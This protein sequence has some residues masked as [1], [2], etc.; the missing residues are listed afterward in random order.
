MNRCSKCGSQMVPG[1]QFCM[2]CGA[3]FS[4]S[5][6]TRRSRFRWLPILGVLLI[7]AGAAWSLTA[8]GV[9]SL[10]SKH[11]ELNA[12][13][14]S[15]AVGDPS[16]SVSGV[17]NESSVLAEPSQP[18]DPALELSNEPQPPSLIVPESGMP[19]DIRRWLEHLKRVDEKRESLNIELTGELMGLVATLRP[20]TFSEED[21][22]EASEDDSRRR[23]TAGE[24]I[25][26]VDAIFSDLITEFQSFPPPPQCRTIAVQYNSALFGTREISIELMEALSNLDLQAAQ[27]L[28]GKSYSKVDS[29]VATANRLVDGL[30]S[31]YGVPNLYKLLVEK[32][33]GLGLGLNSASIM[34]EYSKML[35]DLMDDGG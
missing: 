15:G 14:A 10:S 2:N 20:G 4:F 21:A 5:G 9:F 35:K 16:L 12:L 1:A 32:S 22:G 27:A 17:R 11:A 28:V 29:H 3:S 6:Q 30:C 25:S 26:N 23:N 19:D 7:V 34:E 8:A 24:A 33:G 31:K 18:T 13:E